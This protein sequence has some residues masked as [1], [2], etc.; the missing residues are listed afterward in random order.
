MSIEEFLKQFNDIIPYKF[1]LKFGGSRSNMII[2][3][4][5]HISYSNF[6]GKM[7][8]FK[9]IEGCKSVT[10]YIPL[11]EMD[12]FIDLKIECS[13]PHKL[14]WED[15]AKSTKKTYQRLSVRILTEDYE[16]QL[17]YLSL[18]LTEGCDIRN[19]FC[20]FYNE[21]G[22]HEI[23]QSVNY[24]IDMNTKKV[25][26]R[27]HLEFISRDFET[28]LEEEV[29]FHKENGSLRCVTIS[30][31][32]IQNS[33]YVSILWS[34][35]DV[36]RQQLYFSRYY[37]NEPINAGTYVVGDFA[38]FVISGDYINRLADIEIE[39]RKLEYEND[40]RPYMI[41]RDFDKIRERIKKL[42]D[43]QNNMF[44][45]FVGELIG[46]TIIKDGSKEILVFETLKD[47]YHYFTSLDVTGLDAFN[48]DMFDEYHNSPLYF[49]RL[50]ESDK[51]PMF[52]TK[53]S[54][55]D[56]ELIPLGDHITEEETK[57][58]EWFKSYC[59]ESFPT[60][61]KGKMASLTLEKYSVS[62]NKHKTINN[63]KSKNKHL[64]FKRL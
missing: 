64:N 1:Q 34:E 31:K 47:G 52:R 7:F 40:P 13:H 26:A 15:R 53:I 18:S 30:R 33:A 57:N 3:D 51:T 14:K 23:I 44:S 25:R 63:K 19:K 42:E 10:E 21:D 43:P 39:K 6:K 32:P 20:S 59:E 54:D 49:Q 62:E 41:D 29:A 27:E 17:G 36:K 37:N 48:Y 38:H 50:K 24:D 12:V 5:E 11:E 46:N 58:Y 45:D 35:E 55:G 16:R 4:K 28:G 9:K 60:I 2:S 8:P 61:E 56:E 22:T